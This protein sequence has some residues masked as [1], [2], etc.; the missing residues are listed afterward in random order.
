MLKYVLNYNYSEKN[1]RM[2]LNISKKKI[3]SITDKYDLRHV[4]SSCFV[5]NVFNENKTRKHYKPQNKRLYS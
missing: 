1:L 4:E 2:Y 3:L 5:F